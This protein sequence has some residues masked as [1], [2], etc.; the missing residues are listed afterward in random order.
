MKSINIC[1][2]KSKK[3]HLEV[4]KKN[5]TNFTPTIK[6]GHVQKN[7]VTILVLKKLLSLFVSH[8][9]FYFILKYIFKNNLWSNY[10]V[11]EFGELLLLGNELDFFFP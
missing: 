11:H 3:I 1:C 10:V 9:Y 7:L 6:F 8:D 4:R 2:F 5:A